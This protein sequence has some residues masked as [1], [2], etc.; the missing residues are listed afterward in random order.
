[1]RPLALYLRSRAV[2]ATAAAVLGCVVALWALGLAI[3]HPQGRTLAALLVA[4][5]ATTALAPGLAGPDH[6]LD[7]TAAIAWPPRR[8]AHVLVAGTALAGLLAIALAGEQLAGTAQLAR[9]VAG[10][11]GL[12]ALGAVVL[13]AARAAL[14]PVLWT[15]L[16]LWWA[17][18]MGEPP[19]RPAYKVILT[20]MVQPA[21]T[22]AATVAAVVLAVAGTLVY[23]VR[24]SRR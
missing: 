15:V 16:V 2:P 9:N 24:G 1:M 6:D 17:P 23:A 20:W 14:L 10:L 4:L 18:P 3:D 7:R 22:Q 11:A 13:G 21:G 19:T 8:A 5:A 12:V